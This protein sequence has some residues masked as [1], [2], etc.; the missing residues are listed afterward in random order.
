MVV[1]CEAGSTRISI[2]NRGTEAKSQRRSDDAM[3]HQQWDLGAKCRESR[4]A[5]VFAEKRYSVQIQTDI[6]VVQWLVTAPG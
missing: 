3:H 1:E 5:L 2:A 4:R 6:A